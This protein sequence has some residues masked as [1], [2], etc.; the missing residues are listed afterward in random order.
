MSGQTVKKCAQD[1]NMSRELH[2]DQHVALRGCQET[3]VWLQWMP[4]DLPQEKILTSVKSI[5]PESRSAHINK[6]MCSTGST[7]SARHPF[8]KLPH[9][10][11]LCSCSSVFSLCH[12]TKWVTRSTFRH[13][14]AA[15]FFL[16]LI[17]SHVIAVP[18]QRFLF[19]EKPSHLF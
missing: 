11:G 18:D 17:I 1:K 12:Q 13:T 14:E 10:T 16:W 15:L 3:V 8:E 4:G 5:S 19:L 2:C 9:S 6:Y 7:Q